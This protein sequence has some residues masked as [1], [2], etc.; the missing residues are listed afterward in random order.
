[1]SRKTHNILQWPKGKLD[2]STGPLIM[3][4]LN[5]TPDS[6]S[7][8]G[9]FL[10]TEKA[11]LHGLR[12]AEH[13]AA[14]IDVGAESTRPGSEPVSTDQQIARA[15]PVTEM[16]EKKIDIPISIDTHNYQVA[17]SA[18]DAG[19]SI[20]NDITA[21][22]DERMAQI[23]A[24]QKLPVIL[25]HM[26]ADPATMQIEPKY[27]DVVTDVLVFLIDRAKRAEQAGIEKEKIF[28]DPGIGF[29]KTTEHNLLLL[30]N[31]HK[32]IDTGYRILIGTSR[33]GFIAQITG[34]QDPAERIFGTAAT[35]ALCAAAGVSVLRV[36][37]V[38]EM[39]DVVKTVTAIKRLSS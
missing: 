12:M 28:L 36:H 17:R 37:D 19:A 9:H 7:D 3:G 32:F 23:A 10:D 39:N 11:V 2:F 35:V 21:L 5:V 15:I 29:G 31:I 34:R 4:I 22:N 30:S 18:V 24:E 33:K 1:M 26:Q 6:F 27:E 16:L 13:G 25:M 20:I 8:G 38:A 14:I